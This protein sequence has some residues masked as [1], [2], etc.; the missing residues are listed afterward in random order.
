MHFVFIC[1]CKMQIEYFD[2]YI[3]NRITFLQILHAQ[4]FNGMKQ[5]ESFKT[6]QVCSP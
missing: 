2:T 4:N 1:I 5:N 6:L 3:L